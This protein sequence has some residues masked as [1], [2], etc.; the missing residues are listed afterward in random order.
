MFSIF[1]QI[2]NVFSSMVTI[3]QVIVWALGG[4]GQVVGLVSTAL[5][6]M[7]AMLDIFPFEVA[8][9]LMGVCG[10]LFVLRIFGRA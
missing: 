6:S 5:S 3:I 8:S 2:G 9:C 4:A 7:V 1:S 10:G